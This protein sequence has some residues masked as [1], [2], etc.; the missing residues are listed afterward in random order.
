MHEIDRPQPIRK[1]AQQHTQDNT[2]TS[3]TQHNI[4]CAMH[5]TVRVFKIDAEIW[6]MASSENRKVSCEIWKFSSE[7]AEGFFQ[8]ALALYVPKFPKNG[9]ACFQSCV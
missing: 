8:R 7:D 5:G 4:L 6:N 3:V 9:A 1:C 2:H